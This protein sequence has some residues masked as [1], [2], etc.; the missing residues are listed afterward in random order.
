MVRVQ[1]LAKCDTPLACYAMIR[2]LESAFSA[3]L[4]QFALV[5]AFVF[6]EAFLSSEP[7]LVIVVQYYL[8][9]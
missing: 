9:R 4:G 2:K 7:A 1:P 6:R 5:Q 8:L 3:L